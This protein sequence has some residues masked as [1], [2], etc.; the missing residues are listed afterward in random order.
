M[1]DH[2]QELEVL[3]ESRAGQL[4][5]QQALPAVLGTTRSRVHTP[6]RAA[7]RSVQCVHSVGGADDHHLR[8][9]GQEA[10]GGSALVAAP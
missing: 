6:A 8:G 9:V 2:H 3:R 5:G 10:C 4:K 1:T 7:Q